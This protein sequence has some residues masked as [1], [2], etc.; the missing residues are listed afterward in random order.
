MT[1]W[2][3]TIEEFGPAIWKRLF[4]IVGNEADA[5]DCFQEVFLKAVRASRRK[6]IENMAGFLHVTATRCGI[7][8]L[9]RRRNLPLYS[10]DAFDGE[11]ACPQ[12]ADPSEPLTSGELA[13]ALRAGLSMLPAAQAEAFALQVFD[14]LSYC[15]I[16]E[17]MRIRENHVGV[18]INRA[19]ASLR[20][21][22]KSTAVEY[23]REVPHGT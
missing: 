6:S 12:T 17:H 7:D 3:A 20:E 10:T 5:S 11:P 21:I 15:Q 23:D 1:D 2:K 16:A 9:R 18:L 13:E 22:L 14:E 19:R 4:R 8:C